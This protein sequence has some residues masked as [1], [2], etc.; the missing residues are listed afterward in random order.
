MSRLMYIYGI[1]KDAKNR[2]KA[3]NYAGSVPWKWEA[4]VVTKK[5]I[6]LESVLKIAVMQPKFQV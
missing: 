3:Y 6:H 2:L 1:D 4:S 5:Y